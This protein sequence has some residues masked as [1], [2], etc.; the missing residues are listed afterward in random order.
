[1]PRDDPGD[2]QVECQQP[3]GLRSRLV[4]LVNQVPKD[5]SAF[6]AQGERDVRGVSGDWYAEIDAAARALLVAAAQV[7]EKGTLC[8]SWAD[9]H[10]PIKTL[11][12]RHSHSTVGVRVCSGCGGSTFIRLSSP[13]RTRTIP[14]WRL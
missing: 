2:A 4:T 3:S 12:P 6:H 14:R 9:A 5:V 13:C 8:V 1:M 11:A 7:L 10:E